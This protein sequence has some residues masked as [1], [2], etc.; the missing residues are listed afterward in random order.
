MKSGGKQKYPSGY[1]YKDTS[2]KT[3]PWS[4]VAGRK[5]P[6]GYPYKYNICSNWPVKSSGRRIYPSGYLYKDNICKTD[7]WSQVAGGNTQVVV[8]TNIILLSRPV[9]SQVACANTL[10]LSAHTILLP[11]PIRCRV[12]CRDT[13]GL[14][15]HTQFCYPDPWVRWHAEI[16]Y[17]YPYTRLL[18]WPVS[19][20]A[21][22]DALY[23]NLHTPSAIVTW[24]SDSM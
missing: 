11:Q 7:A 14:F 24:G 20:M 17:G 22:G 21:R 9:R 2:A 5:Y 18:S 12:A 4:Q 15:A 10:G 13:Q 3:D 8:L 16:P 1:P 23:G 6:S 19:P